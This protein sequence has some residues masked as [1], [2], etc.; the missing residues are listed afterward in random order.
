[1]MR[2]RTDSPQTAAPL[3]QITGATVTFTGAQPIYAVSEVDLE[4]HGGEVLAVVGESG[5]GKSTLARA[6]VGLQSLTAGSIDFT[7]TDAPRA[8]RL[9]QMVFQDP[10]SSLNPRLTVRQILAEALV[11]GSARRMSARAQQSMEEL[12]DDVGLS[13]TLLDSRPASLSGGQC[14]RVSI[15][16]ALMSEP[17]LLVCDEV[18]SALDVSIQAQI[19]DLLRDLKERKRIAMLFITHDLGVVR[20]LADR[21]AVM[22]LGKI[23]ELGTTEEIFSGP[24]HPYTQALLSSAVDMAGSDVPAAV[25]D[26]LELGTTLASPSNPP[27]GCHLHPRC[28][29]AE[30]VCAV[31]TPA[32]IAR[33]GGTRSA[34]HFAEPVDVLGRDRG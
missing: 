7:T 24:T 25:R 8:S 28:W 2:T 16:R 5:S 11:G 32:L 6:I 3:A 26:G 31:D 9:T 23:V 4:I 1:M 30:D 18:V 21:V 29:K 14:Q 17:Q 19:L 27:S 34:C 33:A 13:K 20:Q 10:R 12:L 22:Y 15:A